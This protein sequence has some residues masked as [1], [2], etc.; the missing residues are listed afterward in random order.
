MP[1]SGATLQ[2]AWWLLAASI[3]V[4]SIKAVASNP[5]SNARADASTRPADSL[6]AL[7][8]SLVVKPIRLAVVMQPNLDV[9]DAMNLVAR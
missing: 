6:G 3:T 8:C 4:P 2:M 9:T 7:G 5:H 1:L